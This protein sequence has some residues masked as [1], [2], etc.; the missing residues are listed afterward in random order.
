LQSYSRDKYGQHVGVGTQ[1]KFQGSRIAV[2]FT[3]PEVINPLTYVGLLLLLSYAGGRI[4]HFFKAPRVIGYLITGMLLSPSMTGVLNENLVWNELDVVT[5]IALSVI[6][7]SIGGSLKWSQVQR[8]GRQ[9]V[10]ITLSQGLGAFLVAA[11]VLSVFFFFFQ[12]SGHFCD[13]FWSFFF[14]MALVIGAICAAT[15][16]AATLAIVHEYRAKG[17]LTSILLGVVALDDA[18]TILIYALAVGIAQSFVNAEVPSLADQLLKPGLSVCISLGLGAVMG[19]ILRC[20]LSRVTS[21]EAMLG[22]AV[23]AIFVTEGLASSYNVHPLLANMMTGFIVANFVRV[24]ENLFAVVEQIEEPIFG[25]FFVLAGAHLDLKLIGSAGLLALVISIGR[26]TGKVLGSRLGAEIAGA[27]SVVKKY[28]GLGL[29]PTA[30]VT[31][32]LVL[33]A[34]ATFGAGEFTRMMVSGVLGSVIINE[35]LTPFMLR[36]ALFKTGEA[37]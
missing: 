18:L 35:I 26:F 23:G 19:I 25:M 22:I 28:L 13:T 16:P 4:A 9:I 36:F 10:W 17:P 1:Q 6:A 8:L 33:E 37:G 21:R 32:G 14:P 24:Q 27:P 5:H 2:F 29:L 20:V 12:C 15:A 31:V 7:F 3:S 11:L 30:G 34:Q